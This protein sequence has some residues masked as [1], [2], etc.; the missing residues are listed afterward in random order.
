MHVMLMSGGNNGNL[1]VLTYGW[2]FV[3]KP[4]VATKLVEMVTDVLH[5]ENRSQLVPVSYPGTIPPDD[6]PTHLVPLL[7]GAK[8][9]ALQCVDI[10]IRQSCGTVKRSRVAVT[11]PARR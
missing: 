5:S 4:F 7:T 10:L 2:A 6:R 11:A 8:P 1:L 9:R 3:Q